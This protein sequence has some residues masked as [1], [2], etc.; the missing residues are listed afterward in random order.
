MTNKCMYVIDKILALKYQNTLLNNANRNGNG[1]LLM[2]ISSK[3]MHPQAF[4]LAIVVLI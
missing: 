2:E 3:I 1:T 4:P